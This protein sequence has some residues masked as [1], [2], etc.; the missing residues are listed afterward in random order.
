MPVSVTCDL[1]VCS[2]NNL[3]TDTASPDDPNEISF[4]KGEILDIVDKQ[5][6]WW[7]A[8]KAD[9][10][11]GSTPNSCIITELDLTTF[12]SIQLH[13]QII[14]KSFNGL[15]VTSPYEL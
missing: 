11:I 6:K 3:P 9:G 13:L 4:S 15:C 7:Q 1:P 14:S 5:G 10:S 12:V 8:K 2:V